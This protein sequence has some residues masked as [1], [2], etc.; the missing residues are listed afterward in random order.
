[1]NVIFFGSSSF[2]IPVLEALLQSRHR[3]VHVVTTPPKRK[4]RG[5]TLAG[6]EVKEFATQKKL[7][8]LEPEK[9]LSE[10][11]I[12]ELKTLSPDLIVVASYGKLIPETLFSIPKLDTL[13]VHPSLLPKHRGASPIQA[14]ILAGERTTGVSIF[15]VTK[16]LDAGDVYGQTSTEIGENE[17]ALELSDRLASLGAALLLELID[18]LEKGTAHKTPQNSSVATYAPKIKKESGKIDWVRE[19]TNIHNQVR[20]YFSWPSAYTF[21][22]SKRIKIL[23]TRVAA[24]NNS[25]ELSPS[26]TILKIGSETMEV[27]TGS[28]VIALLQVQEEGARAMSAGEFARGKRIQNLERFENQ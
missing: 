19:A 15:S 5:L 17:N 22:R 8:V 16:D 4:G 24:K 27:K 11:V 12:H 3:I 9:L 25:A 2:S 28:G 26:G 13:N 18:Q 6:S 10:M 23:R 14:A 20:A 1:M 7:P 21:F